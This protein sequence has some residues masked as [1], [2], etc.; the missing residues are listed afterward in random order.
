MR[1]MPRVMKRGAEN[2]RLVASIKIEISE[3]TI[4]TA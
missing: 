4:G 2:C 3:K 1:D